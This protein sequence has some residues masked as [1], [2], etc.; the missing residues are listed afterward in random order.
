[1][2]VIWGDAGLPA[3]DELAPGNG[4]GSQFDIR[5]LV[6]HHRRLTAQLQGHAGQ[7]LRCRTH[8]PLTDLWRTC[9]EA[10]FEG[11]RQ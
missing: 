10:V 5:G 7:V 9:K 4:P 11:Q 1:M 3:V 2:D 6:D 8:H